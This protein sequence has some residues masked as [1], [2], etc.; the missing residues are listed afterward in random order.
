MLRRAILEEQQ[1]AL[2]KEAAHFFEA[3]GEA[4]RAESRAFAGASRRSIVRGEE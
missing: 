4:E 1:E 2:E 3:A